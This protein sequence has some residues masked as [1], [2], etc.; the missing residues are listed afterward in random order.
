MYIYWLQYCFKRPLGLVAITA[1]LLYLF[2]L[3][4]QDNESKQ[5]TSGLHRRNTSEFVRYPDGL[6]NR[7]E[8]L[9]RI[10]LSLRNELRLME[11]EKA[12][13]IREKTNLLNRNE[14]LLAQ[15][16]KSKTQLKQLELD[17]SASRRQKFEKSCDA[18]RVAPIIFKPIKSSDLNQFSMP[19]DKDDHTT[20]HQ[21]R[22]YYPSEKS[23]ENYDFDLSI[24]PLTSDF[25]F[26][27]GSVEIDNDDYGLTS[28][29]ETLETNPRYSFMQDKTCLTVHLVEQ[30][31]IPK[32][33]SRNNLVIY[34]SP[35]DD[36]HTNYQELTKRSAIASSHFSKGYFRDGIDVVI[37]SVWHPARNYDLVI[38]SIPP[39]SPIERRYLASYFGQGPN[40]HQL[41]NL[42][43]VLQ[44]IHRNSIDD[45]F[46]FVYD[47]SAATE[48]LCYSSREKMTE[49]SVF[50]IILPDTS[51]D[52]DQNTNDQI[53]LALSRGSIPVIVGKERVRLPFDEV[54]DWRRAAIVLPTARLPELHFIMRS[55]GPADIYRL[56]YF[57]RR[58]FENNLATTRQIVDSL[59]AVMSLERF[60]HPPPVIEDRQTEQYFASNGLL[61]D[62]N[63]T[64]SACQ[65][66]KLDSMS[67]LL[68][69]EIYGPREI[70]FESKKF[71][72]NTSLVFN[73]N[74]DLWNDP[75]HTPIYLFPNHPNDPVPPSEYKFLEPDQGYRPIG[76]GLGGSGLEFSRDLGGDHS[77]EQFTIVLLTYERTNMLMKTLERLKGLAYLNKIIVVWNGVHRRPPADLIW[78]DVGVPIVV[79]RA[80]RN[81][82]NN[83][84]LPFDSIQTE[85][86]F[87]MDDDSPLRPDEIIFAFRVWRQS[88]DRI[89]GFPGRYHAWDNYQ[90]TWMYN[91]NHS[92]ELSMVLTGGA[93][94]HKYYSYIY[95]YFMPNSIRAIVDKFMNCEDIAMNFLVAHL[96]RQPPVKVTSR[97]TFHCAN[98]TSSLS[99]DDSHFRERHECLNMFVSIYG[100]M[101]LLTTQHRSDSILFKTRLPSDKQKC[102]KFV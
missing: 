12:K 83:R 35:T 76:N 46:L 52:I 67:K 51:H 62:T 30:N 24:C 36:N 8:D 64:S 27:L 34:S 93:F 17:I 73:L 88:R 56:K 101:P 90:N 39:Q 7:I 69:T 84:F 77:H 60:N 50:L 85:A 29:R 63:C 44:T 89:V 74:Y 70:P 19:S 21:V 42:E 78:P 57:G 66:A 41:N 23:T 87:S 37:P 40:N 65:D 32:M 82:L 95:S 2:Y 55:I 11:R 14:K 20:T 43:K 72:R 97:W 4:S 47:C 49:M 102:F 59:I 38:G 80:E 100:Y 71:L 1:I 58:I 3:I 92:C 5:H 22:T 28:L 54:I 94:Y 99:E 26:N 31:S 9:K 53:Y 16:T 98:C 81:S 91:S 68:A 33:S 15:I 18:F 45:S 13:I 75:L 6:D 25:K 96:T 86:I 10:K 48:N 61:L 79:A